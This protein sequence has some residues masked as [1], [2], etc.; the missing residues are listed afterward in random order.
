[1]N[2]EKIIGNYTAKNSRDVINCIIDAISKMRDPGIITIPMDLL[3]RALADIQKNSATVDSPFGNING[4]RIY[5]LAVSAHRL[6]GHILHF[7][8]AVAD[9]AK[10]TS[11]DLT[12]AMVIR[13]DPS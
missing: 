6:L 2:Q 4:E 7:D 11:R 13:Y 12:E 1:M 9:S 3:H 10:V 8:D 5:Q